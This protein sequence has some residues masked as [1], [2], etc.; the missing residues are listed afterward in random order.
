[1]DPLN[2][3]V[4]SRR[5]RTYQRKNSVEDNIYTGMSRASNCVVFLSKTYL[6]LF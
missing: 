5:K 3:V 4:L 1:M 6:S 2:Y